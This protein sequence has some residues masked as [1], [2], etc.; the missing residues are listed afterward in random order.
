MDK[1]ETVKQPS[2]SVK[3]T[4]QLLDKLGNL[5]ELIGLISSNKILPLMAFWL[6]TWRNLLKLCCL[7]GRTILPLNK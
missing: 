2:E 7:L 6:K 3:P 4:S 5:L 1:K